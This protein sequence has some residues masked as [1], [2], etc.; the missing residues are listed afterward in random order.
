MLIKR[1]AKKKV[2]DLQEPIKKSGLFDKIYYLRTNHDARLADLTPLEH[3][4]R[5][6]I[7][8]D[9]KPNKDFDPVWYRNYYQDVKEDGGHPLLH[10]L[11]HG[12]KEGRFKNAIECEIKEYAD[13][14]SLSAQQENN[15]EVYDAYYKKITEFD[16]QYYLSTYPDIKE[17]GIDPWEH[18][19]NLGWKEGRNPNVWF[20]TSFYIN[21]YSDVK[22]K[23]I[24]PFTHYQKSGLEEKRKPNPYISLDQLEEIISEG[25]FD[26]DYYLHQYEDIRNAGVDPLYHYIT[27]GYNEHRNPS[28]KFDTFFYINKHKPGS[29]PILDCVENKHK[30]MLP[31]NAISLKNDLEY[32]IPEN[33]NI[34][35]Q[36]H[37]FYPDVANQVVEYLHNIPTSFDLL[38]SVVSE[39]DKIYIEHFFNEV[40]K[41]EKVSV[42]VVPNIGRDISPLVIAFKEAWYEYDY[43]LHIHTKRSP[44]TYFGEEWRTYL[45]DSLLGSEQR[46]RN[47]IHTLEDHNDLAFLYPENYYLVKKATIFDDNAEHINA[48]MRKLGLEEEKSY[49][50]Y[51]FA[52]GTMAWFK[53]EHFKRLIE[54]DFDY[55]DFKDT[56][57][58]IDGT[59]AHA[60]ERVF[61]VYPQKK[62]LKA[63][64]FYAPTITNCLFSQ[65]NKYAER[66]QTVT[67][68][69][70]DDP[71][72]SANPAVKLVP[73]HDLFN[74]DSLVIHWVIPDFQ[75]GAG[76]HMTIFRIVYFLEKLGH[77]QVIWIQNPSISNL[78]KTPAVAKDRIYNHFQPIGKNVDVQF[79]PDDTEWISGDIVIAT[80]CWTAYPVRS[81]SK[82]KNRCYFI[83]DYEPMFHPM[84]ENYLIAEQTYGFGF[85]AI[86]AGPWLKKKAQDNGMTAYDFPLCA[87]ET[88]YSVT[89]EKS[90]AVKDKLNIAFY[91]RSYTPRRAVRLGIAGLNELAKHNDNIHVHCFGQDDL[92]VLPEFDY[93]NHGIL[94]PQELASLYNSC[95][96]GVVF[97]ATNYSLIP[98]EMMACGL[99]I[100]ELD[101]EST[102][103]VFGEDVVTF[104]Q[105][106]VPSIA[107]GVQSLIDN[108]AKREAQIQA[109]LTFLKNISWEKAAQNVNDAL[110]TELEKENYTPLDI[111]SITNSGFSAETHATVVIPT[112]N[113]AGE[114]DPLLDTLLTQKTSFSFD[115]LVIDSASDDATPEILERY[116][117]QHDS[118]SYIGIQRSEFQHGKTRDMG[119]EKAKG[120]Y[121]AF[122]TQDALPY[123]EHWLE[124]LIRSFGV[125]KKIVGVF[126]KHKAYEAHSAFVKRDIHNHFKHF[127]MLPQI[128]SWQ[129]PMPSHIARG[130]RE[131]QMK[132]MFYSDNNSAICKKAWQSIHYPHIDW[133]EDQVWAWTIVQLGLKKY[134][135]KDAIVY[136]SH[137]DTYQTRLKVS[138]IEKDFFYKKF[139]IKLI[140]SKE[141]AVQIKHAQDRNDANYATRQG[142]SQEELEKQVRLNEASIV[143]RSG[144]ST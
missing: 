131:W 60:M 49:A 118:I 104:A 82:F 135:A 61:A 88:V 57:T 92:P 56:N 119:I 112:L 33:K 58:N 64:A 36:L 101:V 16:E 140:G 34:A 137:N 108:P 27:A 72:I 97:S 51:P 107:Q 29:C 47:A 45:F 43:I 4:C 134:Y 68:W 2:R 19:D 70:R 93:T 116:A 142:V 24:N 110:Y 143:G 83:Q 63:A 22:E 122:L 100:V 10:Y 23:K 117:S 8:E 81:M 73:T 120:D 69:E 6:G 95:D 121:V 7:K 91:S 1:K 13:P 54:L 75:L 67:R 21:A 62:G 98:L 25:L 138:S 115:V 123:D 11:L 38:V 3:Y 124:E 86:T 17:A 65:S 32:I 59:L 55:S 141:Q 85:T 111:N 77:R 144:F 105:P 90:Y 96:I 139:G 113:A 37:L 84:G 15:R 80:D 52:A 50:H 74:K 40:E 9:R 35:I 132:M 126:G 20:N 114:I 31:G 26:I 109:G 129:D 44:H 102:R 66:Y 136:H 18:F 87:D 78:S 127:A 103:Y 106:N 39:A 76:G 14:A 5:I 128:Y 30:E 41:V 99:P 130:S 46:V 71:K 42:K 53:T 133:G 94:S 12:K 79:L 28:A 89:E 125:D 48:M